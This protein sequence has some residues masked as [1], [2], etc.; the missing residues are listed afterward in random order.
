MKHSKL[1]KALIIA[2]TLGMF[3]V[4][5]AADIKAVKVSG[6]VGI[7]PFTF[8]ALMSAALATANMPSVKATISA[9]IN[10]LCLTVLPPLTY[11]FRMKFH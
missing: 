11:S 2:F 3:A 1:I 8:T 10:L 9:F 5:N 7:A 4:A 6:A